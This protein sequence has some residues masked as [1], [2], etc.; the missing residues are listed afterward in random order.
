MSDPFNNPTVSATHRRGI[1]AHTAR[2]T[3]TKEN[4]Q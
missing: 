1:D 2:H 3:N 4:P